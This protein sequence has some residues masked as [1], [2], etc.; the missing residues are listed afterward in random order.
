MNLRTLKKLSKK[1]APLLTQL[2]DDRK[3]F[4]AAKGENYHGTFISAR[5][6]W[7]RRKVHPSYEPRNDYTGQRGAQIVYTTRAGRRMVMDP[8]PHPRKGTIMVGGMSGYYEP[9][10]DEESAW[11]A[12]ENMV[13]Q[14]FS[15]WEDIDFDDLTWTPSLTRDLGSVSAIFAAAREMAEER[16]AGR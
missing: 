15:N 1:A 11:T 3:Q 13:R 14:H 4:A 10:W 5:K 2:G 16:R 6:H 7:E 8:T 12:L 9:E